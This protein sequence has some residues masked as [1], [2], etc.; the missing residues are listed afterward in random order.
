MTILFLYLRRVTYSFCWLRA[1]LKAASQKFR[2]RPYEQ[3]GTH[4]RQPIV[5]SLRGVLSADGGCV[6]GE[7]LSGIKTSIHLHD[8]NS[9]LRL[10]LEKCPLYR[11]S[12]AIL[13][14]Q[15]GMD[16][17]TAVRGNVQEILRQNLAV[18]CDCD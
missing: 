18:G 16:V 8:R 7:D 4:F 15:R 10:T 6:L 11:R 12:A 3:I 17:E 9:G 13:G 2:H 14:K 5:K 1:R